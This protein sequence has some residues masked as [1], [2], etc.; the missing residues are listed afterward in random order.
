MAPD[1]R[2]GIDSEKAASS[3]PGG[4][5]AQSVEVAGKAAFPMELDSDF[6]E[7]AAKFSAHAAGNF[8]AELSSDLALEII[9]NEIV[10][11]ACLAMG[12]T[13]AAIVLQ[14]DG[15][16]SCRA[17]SGET[18]PE[19]G[20]RLNPDAGISG[21]C[22]RTRQLQRCDDAQ[23]DPRVDAEASRRL[24]VRS[25]M[26]MPLL[27]DDELLGVF[28]VFSSRPGAFGERDERT[29]EALSQCALKN[30]QRASEPLPEPAEGAST[31]V[32]PSDDA[33]ASTLTVAP[34]LDLPFREDEAPSGRRYDLVGWASGLTVLAFGILF[35]VLVGRYFALQ[36]PART[37]PPSALARTAQST[38]GGTPAESNL[39][40]KPAPP[41]RATNVGAGKKPLST[42]PLRPGRAAAPDSPAPEGGLL[43]YE[44]GKEVFR[45]PSAQVQS[46]LPAKEQGSELTK[47]SSIEPEPA[48]EL[49]PA[50]AEDSLLHR[51]E[52]D[53][54]EAA[55]QAQIQGAVVLDVHIGP[56]GGVQ[57]V[58]VVSGHPLLAQA[59][60]DA[61]KQWRFK[62]HQVKGRAVEMQTRI[63][64]NFRLPQ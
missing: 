31:A 10:E 21:E 26:I 57:E 64:L 11:G 46:E 49:T 47:A 50:A 28:E 7:L 32:P 48:M 9:L 14:R 23:A 51:V 30:L 34:S 17:C 2:T 18:A 45:L 38:Q 58:T 62:P 27:R 16:M 40:E 60:T 42:R 13:G 15:E 44:N 52:P 63:T 20:A 6:A 43:V 22:V 36:I 24:G 12:A 33:P 41:A 55:R 61:V 54:P 37:H 56:G 5:L 29:L 19:L 59:A 53:Y 35:G 1:S 25:V 3:V 4:V 39:A 8:S